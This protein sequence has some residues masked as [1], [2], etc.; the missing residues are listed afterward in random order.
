MSCPCNLFCIILPFV[1]FSL[2]TKDPYIPNFPEHP[3][4]EAE[5]GNLPFNTFCWHIWRRVIVPP[6]F[7]ISVLG[8]WRG[9]KYFAERWVHRRVAEN[10]RLFCPLSFTIAPYLFL[11]AVYLIGNPFF[12]FAFFKGSVAKI[13]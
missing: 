12:I 11:N 4:Q 10:A 1:S 3:N 9:G 5:S 7:F 8:K 2:Q 6:D 13:S